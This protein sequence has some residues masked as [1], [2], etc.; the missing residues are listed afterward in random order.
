[1][2]DRVPLWWE[3]ADSGVAPTFCLNLVRGLSVGEVFAAYGADPQHVRTLSGPEADMLYPMAHPGALLRAGQFDGWTFCF[4]DREAEGPKPGVLARLSEH[5]EVVHLFYA[6]GMT[7]VERLENGQ[8]LESF[9]PGQVR[10]PRGAGPHTLHR[11][12]DAEL[13]SPQ[14]SAGT[15]AALR[16]VARHVGSEIHWEGLVGPLQTVYLPG[17]RREPGPTSPPTCGTPHPDLGHYLG[18]LGAPRT[19]EG[20]DGLPDS[21]TS[22]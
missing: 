18:T 13:Q 4:E 1:M 5:S 22:G 3:W 15:G 9:E 10:P 21:R 20:T 8:R 19:A 11:A 14:A 17:A 2:V 12:V 16:A 7:V 6:V